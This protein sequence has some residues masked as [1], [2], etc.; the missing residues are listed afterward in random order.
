M[1]D[2]ATEG[3]A[4]RTTGRL[5]PHVAVMALLMAT[6]TVLYFEKPAELDADAG[7]R[8]ELPGRVGAWVGQDILFC[9]NEACLRSFTADE[10]GAADRCTVCGG[11]LARS[12]SRAERKILPEDTVLEK[13]CYAH[14]S[15]RVLTVSVVVSGRERVS[16]HRPQICLVGQGFDIVRARRV[17]VDL[18]ERPPL[19]LT[20]L[21]IRSQTRTGRP[22][23]S[24][25]AYWF[26]ARGVETA[27]HLVRMLRSGWD[28]ITRNRA[29][30][31]AYLAISTGGASTDGGLDA[32]VRE[33][34]RRFYPL[35]SLEPDS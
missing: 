4:G 17:A 15:G 10:L 22:A 2:K 24:V 21:D 14:P 20:V 23:E 30:R 12:W 16:I 5:A 11:E 6:S 26:T 18:P 31:W 19:D 33:F 25:Y 3:R 9:Q 27:S 34:V 32:P 7:I 8:T 28:R 35:I 1:G 29:R 13:K